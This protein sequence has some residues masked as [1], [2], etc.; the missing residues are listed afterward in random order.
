MKR[1]EEYKSSVKY[2]PCKAAPYQ[3]SSLMS[4]LLMVPIIRNFEGPP[5]TWSVGHATIFACVSIVRADFRFVPSQ[6]EMLLCNDVSDWLG[7][8]L[9]SALILF[10]HDTYKLY[11]NSTCLAMK[12]VHV[13]FIHIIQHKKNLTCKH[14][15]YKLRFSYKADIL[16]LCHPVPSSNVSSIQITNPDI[17]CQILT[18]A[19]DGTE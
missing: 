6:W 1:W 5:T 17:W 9:E 18:Y 7:A 3:W 8:S 11:S 14:I 16:L 10:R 2:C 4:P 13:H 15:Y 19:S 12:V